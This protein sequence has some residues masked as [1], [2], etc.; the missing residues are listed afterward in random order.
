MGKRPAFFKMKKKTIY[1]LLFVLVLFF[2]ALTVLAAYTLQDEPLTPMAE[3]A[4]HYQPLSVPPERNA[5]VGI[6]GLDAPAGSDF[7]VAG[8][9]NIHRANQDFQ[10]FGTYVPSRENAPQTVEKLEFSIAKYTYSCNEEITE[11]CL[12]EIGAEAQDIQKLL[13]KNDELIARY[14]HIQAM[15]EFSNTIPG[16]VEFSLPYRGLLNLSRLLSAKAVLDI[17]NRHLQEGLDFLEKDLNFYRN[18]S[19]SREIGIIDMMVAVRQIQRYANLLMLLARQEKLRDH[20]DRIRRLLMPLDAPKETFLRALWREEVFISQGLYHLGEYMDIAPA[21]GTYLDQL[22]AL[23][24]FKKNMSLN[25]NSEFW[26]AERRLIDATTPLQLHEM[27]KG[28]WWE[29]E[30]RLRVCTVPEDYF[31]CRHITNFAGEIIVII[32]QP[33]HA[34]YLLRIHDIDARLRLFRAQLEFARAAKNGAKAPETL[35]ARLGPETFN[36]YTGQPFE[37]N[38]ETETLGFTPAAGKNPTRVEVRLFPPAPQ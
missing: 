37:W 23:F 34:Q 12:E 4:L 15:P 38:P 36:P 14:L 24:F 2:I 33:N 1:T 31:F 30:I 32:A 18:I 9:E 6:A 10:R 35:L 27:R 7:I 3:Q 22:I 13:E 8:V 25:L 16:T 19:A 11:N 5:F 28:S 17:Q 29:N 26:I 20:A 21:K